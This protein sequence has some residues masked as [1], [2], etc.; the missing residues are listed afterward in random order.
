MKALKFIAPVLFILTM[1]CAKE[2]DNCEN[3]SP[4]PA[5]VFWYT[6]GDFSYHNSNL[7]V[8]FYV[9]SKTEVD[10]LVHSGEYIFNNG[11]AVFPTHDDNFV[12]VAY[13]DSNFH[14]QDTMFA[15]FMVDTC[16]KTLTCHFTKKQRSQ[17]PVSAINVTT[18]F[19]EIENIPADYLVLITHE[20]KGL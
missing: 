14:V 8:Q 18:G 20:R 15:D 13:G 16:T 1:A 19:Y 6:Y 12:Y 3:I 9:R 11:T 10:S 4:I 17:T 5:T 2:K 7:P